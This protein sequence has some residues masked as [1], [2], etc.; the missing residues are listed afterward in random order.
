[1]NIELNP[2]QRSRLELLSMYV[3]ISTSQMLVDAA[4]LLLDY[5]AG[6]CRHCRPA[7]PQ[8]FLRDEE[9]EARFARILHH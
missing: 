5:D 1:M 2:E 7:E 4:H 8:K 6:R 3:G 9:L